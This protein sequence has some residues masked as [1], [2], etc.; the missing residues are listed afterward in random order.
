MK[1]S[2]DTPEQKNW[3]QN[4]SLVKENLAHNLECYTREEPI[5][6]DRE[7]LSNARAALT[8]IE[9]IDILVLAKEIIS[10]QKK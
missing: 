10:S 3:L 9:D 6:D 8:L 2:K 1:I 7:D 5:V 4:L